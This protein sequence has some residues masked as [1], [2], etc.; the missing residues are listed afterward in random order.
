MEKFHFFKGAL[1]VLCC[2]ILIVFVYNI[3]IYFFVFRANF[4]RKDDAFDEK[5]EIAFFG[6]K[7]NYQEHLKSVEFLESLNLP[8]LEI[9]SKDNLNLKALLWEAQKNCRGSVI[10]MHGF[11][12][13]P[14]SEFAVIAQMFHKMGFNVLLPYQRA[15]GISEGKW[16]TFGIKER[17]D[18]LQWIEKVNSI[19]GKSLPVFLGGISMGSSTVT[20]TCGFDL[21][22]NVRGCIADCGF[23]SP[24]EIVYWTMTKK[25]KIPTGIARLL[26]FSANV[27]AKIFAGFDFNEYSTYAALKKTDIPFLFITGT[28]DH[29]VP[30]E[31]SLSNFLILKQKNPEIARLALFEGAHHAVSYLSDERRYE[32][33]ILNFVNKYD[34]Q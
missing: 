27:Q 7:K 10:L 18:C 12:S 13:E 25:R 32:S 20:M 24:Y 33:E 8:L 5:M 14:V 19:Y 28:D 3:C 29:T 2:L 26:V 9:K 16:I 22:E 21:P 15:H 11:H 6:G 4:L 31:M 34:W 1:F 17:F 30:H 23:T